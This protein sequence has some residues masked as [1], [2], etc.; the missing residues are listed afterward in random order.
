MD[1]NNVMWTHPQNVLS[2]K[3]ELLTQGDIQTN[4]F[5]LSLGLAI[6]ILVLYAM[7]KIASITQAFSGSRKEQHG[8]TSIGALGSQVS[9]KI[10]EFL[11][12]SDISNHVA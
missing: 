11:Q 1:P 3:L 2:D 6:V 12:N 7:N 9:T 4:A 5:I 10:T 8:Q